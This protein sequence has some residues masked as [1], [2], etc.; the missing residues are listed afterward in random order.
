M[1]ETTTF[2]I[3]IVILLIVLMSIATAWLYRRIVSGIVIRREEREAI[4]VGRLGGKAKE[5]IERTE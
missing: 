3:I 4:K 2:Q 5:R 1:Q